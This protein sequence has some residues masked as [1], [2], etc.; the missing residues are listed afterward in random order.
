MIDG[1]SRE[2]CGAA[3]GARGDEAGFALILVLATLVPAVLLVGMF[4]SVLSS[5]SDELSL[6]RGRERALHAAESGIDFAIFRGR[7]GLLGDGDV[8]QATLGV[9]TRYRIDA[10][11]LLVDGRDNDD[12]GF[13]DAA[14]PEND[15]DVFQVIVSGTYRNQQRRL[16][17]YLGPVP[18]LP[19]LRSALAIAN[20][21][22]DLN[23]IGSSRISGLDESGS[24]DMPGLAIFRPGTVAQLGSTL[25]GPE[26]NRI[27]GTGATTPSLGEVDPID[28]NDIVT[29]VQNVADIVLTSNRYT[30]LVF[31]DT[32]DPRITYRNGN[33]RIGGV[34]RGAGI[35]VVTG[36]LEVLGDFHFEGIVV[37]LGN[38]INSSGSAYIR[39]AI[40]QGADA[41]VVDLRGDFDLQFSTAA[42]DMANT[43]TGLYVAFNGWQE[44][45]K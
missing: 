3:R 9:D 34:S 10:T 45:R 1:R 42:L 33:V 36:D 26:G 24:T 8:Y 22:I 18:L 21:S 27:S 32:S 25:S 17:A 40:V 7:R 35:L 5:R 11:H 39:G 2:G 30:G 29:V 4:G 38:L 14:D 41:D 31:G 43:N 16:A 12:D 20:P 44:L 6:Q 37:V 23:L 15:E 13:A 28:L 19:N